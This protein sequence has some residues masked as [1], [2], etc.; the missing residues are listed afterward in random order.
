MRGFFKRLPQGLLCVL[1][2]TAAAGITNETAGVLSLPEMVVTATRYSDDIFSIPGTVYRLE[3]DPSHVLTTPDTLGSLPSVMLQKTAQGLGSPYLRGFTGY[4]TLWMIDGIRLNNAVFRDGPNPYGNTIDPWSIERTEVVMGPASVLY[5]SD[6]IGGAINLFPW[7]PSAYNGTPDWQGRI[8]YRGATADKGHGGRMQVSGNPSAYLGLTGGLTRKDIGDLSGGKHV[9][10][11]EKT[12]YDAQDADLN[13]IL[14]TGENSELQLGFQRSRLDDVWRAHRTIYGLEWHGTSRGDDLVHRFDHE[15]DLGYARLRLN[16][17]G[18]PIDEL[19]VT[20]SRQVQ[21]E[22][23]YRVRPAAVADRQGF[24]VETWG[25]TFQLHSATPLGRWVYGADYYQDRVDAY[26][27]AYPV[28]GSPAYQAKQPPVADNATYRTLGL[29]VQNTFA[30]LGD[31]LEIV[32][33]LRYSHS[34]ARAAD[35]ADSSSGQ[36]VDLDSSW[37]ALVGSLRVLYALSEN[38]RQVL[39]A[40]VSQGFRAP[41]LSDLTRFD[42][43]RSGEV[44]TPATD[45]DSEDY[46]AF[47]AGLKLGFERLDTRISLH[48]TRIDGMIVRTPTGRLIANEPEVTKRNAGDGYVQGLDGLL[49]YD[50]GAGWSAWLSGSWMYGRV[51]SYPEADSDRERD[52]LS[53]LMPP[54]AGAGLCWS[55]KHERWWAAIAAQAAARADKLSEGDRRDVQRIPPGGTPGYA[56]CRLSGGLRLSD[57]ATL[58]VSIENIFDKD[59]RIHGSGVNEPGRGLVVNFTGEF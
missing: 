14:R 21:R 7:R 41:N 52:Y 22:D 58:A 2:T 4:R 3:A 10:R 1:V 6:A 27:R 53:R 31:K 46:L 25:A 37:D 15:R 32:P 29:F 34:R 20:A 9:G 51:D 28:A 45:L 8:L 35:V 54:T 26:A 40:G 57:A 16:F 47:E 30:T 5:G 11:Q 23:R 48:H 33:G 24:R 36:R 13:A 59:Y 19:Q 39:F 55:D 44:E 50:L 12:G 42:S 56:V 43:A 18:A 49:E 38:R 17:P